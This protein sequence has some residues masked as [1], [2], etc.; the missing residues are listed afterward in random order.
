SLRGTLGAALGAPVRVSTR[1]EAGAAGASMMA[2]VAIGAYRTMD[3][4]IA[5]WV[6]PELGAAEQPKAEDTERMN[7][8][9][10]AYSTVRRGIAPAWDI[11][12][13]R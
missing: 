1:E 10:A 12:A 13:A 11:L 4:C 7:R 3:D 9:F 5:D 8:L 2:A 6:T